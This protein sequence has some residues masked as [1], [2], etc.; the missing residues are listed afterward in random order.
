LNLSYPIK[1]KFPFLRLLLAYPLIWVCFCCIVVPMLITV[2]LLSFWTS[3]WKVITIG[4][5]TK[6]TIMSWMILNACAD[7]ASLPPRP[8]VIVYFLTSPY[9]HSFSP[10]FSLSSCSSFSSSP[11]LM[12]IKNFSFS[13]Y[14]I[15]KIRKPGTHLRRIS[16][17]I[18][19]WYELF[20]FMN[21][22]FKLEI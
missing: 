21:N 17:L 1:S 12:F 9:F 20:F 16:I 22:T 3:T 19:I 14:R 6:L 7:S 13:Y 5:L 15:I 10:F 2:V 18:F 4:I 8:W 11:F